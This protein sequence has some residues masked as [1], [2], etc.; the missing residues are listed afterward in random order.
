MI[1]YFD[2]FDRTI[3]EF[4][5]R[6]VPTTI[7]R[8]RSGDKQWF[9][10]NCWRAHDAKQT[11]YRTNDMFSSSNQTHFVHF[12]NDTTNCAFDSDVNYV[13]ATVNL[14]LRGRSS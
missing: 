3:S 11:A 5:I 7:L 14:E 13:H 4:I 6:L 1:H 2:A 8:S 9:D 12:D 10:A